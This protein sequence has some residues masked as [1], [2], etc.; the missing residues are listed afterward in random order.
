LYNA[1]D[2]RQEMGEPFAGI[3]MPVE[4]NVEP[5]PEFVEL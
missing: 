4:E 1:E 5:A 2:V 3:K